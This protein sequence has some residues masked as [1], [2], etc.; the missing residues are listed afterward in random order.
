MNKR[1]FK[2][3]VIAVFLAL[4][5]GAALLFGAAEKADLSVQGLRCEYLSNP[6]GIDVLKPRL[7][8]V[9]NPTAGLRG[10]KAY[11][12]LVA[13]TPAI[14]RKNQGDQAECASQ[15]VPHRVRFT[16]YG[17]EKPPERDNGYDSAILANAVSIDGWKNPVQLYAK[18]P[19]IG[20]PCLSRPYKDSQ[21]NE[22]QKQAVQ[23]PSQIEEVIVFSR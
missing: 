3:L 11:R 2:T 4:A 9:L 7:S 10:Q 14:L 12:V 18:H 6:L 8:W 20:L 21:P 19:D 16:V 5:S 17:Q 15:T 13:S 23:C 1:N 22:H